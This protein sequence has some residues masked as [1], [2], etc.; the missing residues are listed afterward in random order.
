MTTINEH[1]G[2]IQK[3]LE[4][5]LTEE[6]PT[7]RYGELVANERDYF[8]AIPI[9][10]FWSPD[11]PPLDHRMRQAIGNLVAK[12]VVSQ[13]EWYHFNTDRAPRPASPDE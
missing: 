13:A 9:E 1:F 12:I 10:T 2:T 8:A 4:R 5:I 3:D 11:L 7:S 6:E